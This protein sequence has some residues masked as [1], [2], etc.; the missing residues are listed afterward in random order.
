[1]RA[2]GNYVGIAG[3]YFDG[4]EDESNDVVY[5]PDFLGW[6]SSNGVLF[7]N[8][9]VGF[10][11]M[12]DGSSNVIALGEQSGFI[13]DGFGMRIDMRSNGVYGSFLGTNN[14]DIPRA[15]SSW[16]NS[17]TWPRAY[18]VATIRYDFDTSFAP[19]MGD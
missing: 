19:G 2:L 1:M 13:D 11:D 14:G 15:G 16:E 18:N 4:L 7:A 10:N 17:S 8:S 6:S 9:K 3:A 12:T 5:V